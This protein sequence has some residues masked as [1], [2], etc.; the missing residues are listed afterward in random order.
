VASA[1]A[2]ARRAVGPHLPIA[3]LAALVVTGIGIYARLL[4][5]FRAAR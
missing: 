1:R 5:G 4:P 2:A 3:V